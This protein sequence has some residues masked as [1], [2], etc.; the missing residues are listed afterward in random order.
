MTEVRFGQAINRALIDAMT[1]DSS[2]VLFGEDVGEAGGPFGVYRPKD[3]LTPPAL[4]RAA[5]DNHI[6][7][8]R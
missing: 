8:D 4:R 6:S 2:V 5:C 3:R 7:A 1:E